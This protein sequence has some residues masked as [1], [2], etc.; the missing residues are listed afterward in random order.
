MSETEITF[1]T[2]CALGHAR[3][4]RAKRERERIEKK[5]R[6]K[7]GSWRRRHSLGEKERKTGLSVATS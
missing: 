7:E 6:G 3:R 1:W 4:S 2:A 5:G